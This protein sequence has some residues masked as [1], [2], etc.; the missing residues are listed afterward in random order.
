M[1]IKN[2]TIKNYRLLRSVSVDLED[3]ITLV[4]GKNNSGKTS[5]F[6]VLR[7]LLKISPKLAMLISK[8]PIPLLRLH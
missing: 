1:R 2:I 3:D 4:V 7:M 8:K 5:F 6:E